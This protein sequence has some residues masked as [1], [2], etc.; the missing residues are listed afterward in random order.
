MNFNWLMYP[1]TG[2]N[3]HPRKESGYQVTYH[4]QFQV[5]PFI[6]RVTYTAPGWASMV[7]GIAS[8][9]P[10]WPFTDPGFRYD[11]PWLKGELLSLYS[12]CHH[13]SSRVILFDPRMSPYDSWLNLHVFIVIYVN[14]QKLYDSLLSLHDSRGALHDSRVCLY[15]SSINEPPWD[16]A[17]SVTS[18]SL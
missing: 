15:D 5:D 16:H 1:R 14:L 9:A 4:R 6:S 11:S 2:S 18:V 10:E 3:K 8:T 7:P 12:L 17:V 13:S